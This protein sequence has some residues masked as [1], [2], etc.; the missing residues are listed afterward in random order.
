MI[1]SIETPAAWAAGLMAALG[2]LAMLV[3]VITEV[4][5]NVGVLKK[6]PTDLLVLVLSVGLC[7]AAY[8]AAAGHYGFGGAWYMV[9]GAAAAGFVVA[10]IAMF[11]WEKL[12]ALRQ[13]FVPKTPGS[14]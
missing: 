1:F 8:F 14:L 10:F 7:V 3:S 11:G 13:R 12:G 9:L 2:A 6:L 4:V 5:K